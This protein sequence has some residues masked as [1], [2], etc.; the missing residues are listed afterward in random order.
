MTVVFTARS[1][2]DDFAGS[3]GVK[4]FIYAVPFSLVFCS[5]LIKSNLDVAFRV[6]H[7]RLPINPGIVKVKTTLDSPLGRFILANAITLTPGT[8]T[9]DTR[10]DTFFIHWINISATDSKAATKAIVGKFE[11][12]LGVM[13][14]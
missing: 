14:G 10:G 8:L 7:P 1:I 11:K 13:F 3:L 5:E 12:Y 6:L 9:V 4:T 2:P